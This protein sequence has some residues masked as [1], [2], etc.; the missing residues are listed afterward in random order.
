MEKKRSESDDPEHRDL[1][2]GL[3]GLGDRTAEAREAASFAMRGD[4]LSLEQRMR[5]A[6]TWFKPPGTTVAAPA[7]P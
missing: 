2:S 6:L 7:A 5:A 1:V 4:G 3:R